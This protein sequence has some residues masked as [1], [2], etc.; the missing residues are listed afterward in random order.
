[1]AVRIVEGLHQP[2]QMACG[3][4]HNQDME[5]LVTATP[6]VESSRSPLLWDSRCIQA[7]T[8]N[9]QHTLQHNPI[10]SNTFTQMLN[11]IEFDAVKNW[12]DS[13][14]SHEYEHERTYRTK[15][16]RAELR[17]HT[18]NASSRC[19]SGDLSYSSA[20]DHTSDRYNSDLP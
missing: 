5:D 3:S 19:K 17:V 2:H 8:G 10:K 1:M 18:G 12:K 4:H 11:T 13:G 6:Y 14:K 7:C 20:K 9:I 16:R 15:R